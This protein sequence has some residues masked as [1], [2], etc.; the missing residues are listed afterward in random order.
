[1]WHF[2]WFITKKICSPTN[3]KL[4]VKHFYIISH[5]CAKPRKVLI[6]TYTWMVLHNTTW[7]YIG[8]FFSIFWCWNSCNFATKV[9]KFSRNYTKKTKIFKISGQKKANFHSQKKTLTYIVLTYIY[10]SCIIH[11]HKCMWATKSITCAWS[12]NKFHSII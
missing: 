8:V 6:C 12:V 9:R 10:M 5:E 1:M 4:E 11:L 2:D 3:P 7:T